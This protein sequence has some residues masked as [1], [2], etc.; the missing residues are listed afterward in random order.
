MAHGNLLEITRQLPIGGYVLLIVCMCRWGFG[1][2]GRVCAYVCLRYARPPPPPPPHDHGHD[3]DHDRDHDH[4]HGHDRDHDHAAHDDD[5][6]IRVDEAGLAKLAAYGRTLLEVPDT[7]GNKTA[8]G[9]LCVAYAGGQWVSGLGISITCPLSHPHRTL[10]IPAGDESCSLYCD[11]TTPKS[12]PRFRR[13]TS[14]SNRGASGARNRDYR[15]LRATNHPLFLD[16]RIVSADLMQ[17]MAKPG[18][19]LWYD[20]DRA[21]STL[22]PVPPAVDQWGTFGFAQSTKVL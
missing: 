6:D 21:A 14:P 18:V 3:R 20:F 15:T 19:Q 2:C 5:L 7:G 9:A 12:C 11:Q 17:S 16:D 4:D 22:P 1:A 8:R 10:H 13:S